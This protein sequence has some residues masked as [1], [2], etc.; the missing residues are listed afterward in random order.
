METW[1]GVAMKIQI[2]H[3]PDSDDAF[4]FYGLASGKVPSNGFEIEHVLS[5]IETLNRAAFEGT[6][7]I[8]RSNAMKRDFIVKKGGWAG[9]GVRLKQEKTG[10]S[11]V[12]TGL[13]PNVLLQVL[14]GGLVAY[15]FL[16]PS[17]K[18]MESEVAAFIETAPEFQQA[19]VAEP[20]RP[21]RK[22]AA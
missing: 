10:T 3:S 2:A 20:R 6:Y 14:F 16:R 11:F 8:V 19:P 13:I 7:E 15:L 22:K 9:V 21:R 17:W 12:F 1:T 18:A 4:M 5:D